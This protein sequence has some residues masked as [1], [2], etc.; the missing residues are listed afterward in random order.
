MNTTMHLFSPTVILNC[1]SLKGQGRLIITQT[2]RG[3]KGPRFRDVTELNSL[4]RK[5]AT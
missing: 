2:L 5:V 4:T 1:Y 3:T